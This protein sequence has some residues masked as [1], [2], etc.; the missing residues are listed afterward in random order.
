VDT[1]RR[2]TNAG[3]GQHPRRLVTTPRAPSPA[4]T[5]GDET[6]RLYAKYSE[7]LYRYCLA[8]LRSREDAEDAVQSTFI[9]VHGALGKGVTPRFEAAW[10]YKIAHNVCLSRGEV[11]GRRAQH[12]S[13]HDLSELGWAM[14]APEHPREELIG[15]SAAL[16]SM[17]KNL[18][19]PILLRE[20]QGLSYAEIAE[21]LDTSVSAVETLIF[22]GRRHLAAAL[23]PVSKRPRRVI[24]GL[25]DAGTA[26][27]GIRVLLAHLR[28]LLLAAGPAKLAAGAAIVA[29]GGAGIG[30]AVLAADSASP[31]PAARASTVQQVVAAAPVA[32]RSVAALA[33]GPARSASRAHPTAHPTATNAPT[34]GPATA[35]FPAAA[36][37][38][39]AVPETPATAPTAALPTAGAVPP[40]G[41]LPPAG[42]VPTAIAAPVPVPAV[43]VPTLAPRVTAPPIT[44]PAVTA[45]AIEVPA[46]SANE[47]AVPAVTVPAVTVPALPVTVPG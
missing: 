11:T 29:L 21:A 9:R 19:D 35:T 31:P 24:A 23:E 26:Y 16:G 47:P 13:P 45:P 1:R 14:A 10:L 12:E 43:A 39:P 7:Q 6:S 34:T 2:F 5:G 4:P 42:A 15:L 3:N 27:G 40:A 22:R 18:R 8:R 38:P 32:R 44:V 25:F 30:R 20:W 37:A 46:V 17:P 36:A 33:T 41:A 28:G